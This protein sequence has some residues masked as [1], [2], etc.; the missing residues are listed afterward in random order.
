MNNDY[1]GL[2]KTRNWLTV[3]QKLFLVF[4]DSF[5]ELDQ[6]LAIL[7]RNIIKKNRLLSKTVF[8]NKNFDQI[9]LTK[10]DLKNHIAI[11]DQI[12]KLVET[13]ISLE[14]KE[15][16]EI[17]HLIKRMKKNFSRELL[18]H[19]EDGKNPFKS[20]YL[21]LNT[22]ERLVIE[23]KKEIG[24]QNKLLHKI[25]LEKGVASNGKLLI[26][27]VDSFKKEFALCGLNVKNED[28]LNGFFSSFEYYAKNLEHL[29][30]DFEIAEI[31]SFFADEH[32]ISNL[33]TLLINFFEKH[34][35]KIFSSKELKHPE[36]MI[37]ELKS[38]IRGAFIKYLNFISK[39]R[40]DFRRF[41]LKKSR[42]SFFNESTI[43][44]NQLLSEV[45]FEFLDSN[46]NSKNAFL[47]K[48]SSDDSRCFFISTLL[49]FHDSLVY[50]KK[51]K[52]T[53]DEIRKQMNMITH[54]VNSARTYRGGFLFAKGWFDKFA[55]AYL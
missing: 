9:V 30:L 39:S 54:F 35:A 28:S 11:F 7:L 55:K 33:K 45:F 13:E 49:C 41:L 8:L 27:L 36:R 15:K 3:N 5:E 14:G 46:L 48:I 16:K 52:P 32:N 47:S 4:K 6:L 38:E 31:Y 23:L 51:T 44:F 26:D 25:H 24:L 1:K 18:E 50:F 17:V 2:I 20:L 43:I 37:S 42:D 22:L 29:V 19:K 34:K 21:K 12:N 53:N 40:M 10:D